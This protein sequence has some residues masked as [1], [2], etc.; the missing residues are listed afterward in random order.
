MEDRLNDLE[1]RFA[2]QEQT[3]LSLSETLAEQQNLIQRLETRVRQ[4]DEKLRALEPSP[5]QVDAPEPPP[6]HY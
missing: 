3:L 1:S 6:P 4:L 2:F 5:L